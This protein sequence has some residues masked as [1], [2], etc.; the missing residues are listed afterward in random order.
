MPV[1]ILGGIYSGYFT[2]TEAG[3]VAALYAFI[4]SVFVYKEIKLKDTFKILGKSAITSSIIMFII[5]SAGLFAWIISKEGLPR[6]AAEF[7][8]V[9]QIRHLSS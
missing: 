7:L 9:F 5:S 6:M 3:A 2:P 1:I 4:I 8:S